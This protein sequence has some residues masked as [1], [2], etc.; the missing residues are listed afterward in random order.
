MAPANYVNKVKSQIPTDVKVLEPATVSSVQ[1]LVQNQAS[2]P[3]ML[4]NCLASHAIP[5]GGSFNLTLDG[6]VGYWVVPESLAWDCDRGPFE[7]F[8]VAANLSGPEIMAGV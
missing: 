7:L 6:V 8:Y 2:S 5:A 3:I 4:A 1:L